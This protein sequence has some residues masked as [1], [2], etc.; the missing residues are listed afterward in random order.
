[1]NLLL[2]LILIPIGYLAGLFAAIAFIS[3]VSWVRAYPPVAD[4]PALITMTALAVMS[5]AFILFTVIGTF[6]L[7]PSLALIAVAEAFSIRSALYFCAAGLAV[8][9]V[10][11]RTMGAEIY[12]AIPT[13]PTTVAAAG[14]AGGL[15]YWVASGH[16]SGR[17]SRTEPARG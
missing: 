7:L 10:L 12:R 6:A 2:R 1:V 8:A 14:I 4:D 3:V 5:D 9:G 17:P 13:D 16:W 15:G 11:S